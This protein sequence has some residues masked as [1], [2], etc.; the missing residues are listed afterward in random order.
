M[1]F[2]FH[3]A[4]LVNI[5]RS[6]R[7]YTLLYSQEIRYRIHSGSQIVDNTHR[8]PRIL[9]RNNDRHCKGTPQACSCSHHHRTE[10]SMNSHIACLL[11]C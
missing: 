2:S 7:C 1:F 4:L 6:L 3:Q 8:S 5:S 9:L 10:S 11:A